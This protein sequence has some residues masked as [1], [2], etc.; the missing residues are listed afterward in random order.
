MG[1][2]MHPCE[3]KKVIFVP[4]IMTATTQLHIVKHGVVRSCTSIFVVIIEC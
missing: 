3:T 2:R 4:V 1:S